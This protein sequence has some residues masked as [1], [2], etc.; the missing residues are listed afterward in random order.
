MQQ[1]F[2]VEQSE[3]LMP[4]AEVNRVSMRVPEFT[5]TDPELWFNIID[6]N[7]HTAGIVT[8]AIKFGYA[9]TAI[10]PRYTLEVRDVIMNPPAEHMRR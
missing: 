6:R 4:G 3:L 9:L 2:R 7:F 8:D 5:S 10:G 1:P